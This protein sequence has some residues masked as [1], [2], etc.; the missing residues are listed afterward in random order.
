MNEGS[1]RLTLTVDRR[2]YMVD[3]RLW[4]VHRRPYIVDR[5]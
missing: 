5:N 1:V 2:P 3:R 4:T